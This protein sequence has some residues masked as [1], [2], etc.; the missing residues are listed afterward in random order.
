MFSVNNCRFI[1]LP[2]SVEAQG[3]VSASSHFWWRF[4]LLW[5]DTCWDK[6]PVKSSRVDLENLPRFLVD[7]YHFVLPMVHFYIYSGFSLMKCSKIA[8][9][10]AVIIFQWKNHPAKNC[11]FFPF[12]HKTILTFQSVIFPFPVRW[13]DMGSFPAEVFCLMRK[14]APWVYLREV[15]QGEEWVVGKLRLKLLFVTSIYILLIDGFMDVETLYIIYH[16]MSK[17]YIQ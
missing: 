2:S 4:T 11:S 3:S 16:L 15:W 17:S 9:P 6:V 7:R 5:W 14:F 8:F 13:D 10:I 1:L 12:P